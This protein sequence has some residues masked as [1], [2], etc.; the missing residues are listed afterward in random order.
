MKLNRKQMENFEIIKIIDKDK[1][2]IYSIWDSESKVSICS[3]QIVKKS[4][5]YFSRL[6]LSGLCSLSSWITACQRQ[7]KETSRMDNYRIESLSH[8]SAFVIVI[9]LNH[10]GC[11]AFR[12]GGGRRAVWGAWCVNSRF[13][14]LFHLN[15]HLHSDQKTKTSALR[16]C[17]IPI[18]LPSR[19]K[20]RDPQNQSHEDYIVFASL[21]NDT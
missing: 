4:H 18:P 13:I 20:A 9:S 14:G 5:L 6:F 3:A 12:T 15:F 7:R 1:R 2:F 10:G 8:R 19:W 21:L 11:A 16:F 17:S